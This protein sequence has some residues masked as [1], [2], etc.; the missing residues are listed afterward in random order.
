MIA[1]FTIP[2]VNGLHWGVNN[3]SEIGHKLPADMQPE[4]SVGGE[5]V[6]NH[7]G[8]VAMR[9]RVLAHMQAEIRRSAPKVLHL[10]RVRAAPSAGAGLLVQDFR[11]AL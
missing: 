2:H 10:P 1:H 9:G 5:T 4:G 6:R 7:P 11:T 8:H 3:Q